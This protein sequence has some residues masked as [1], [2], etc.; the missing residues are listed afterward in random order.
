MRISDAMPETED[1]DMPPAIDAETNVQN[2]DLAIAHWLLGPERTSIDPEANAAYWQT[3]AASW[4]ITEAEARR[5]LC[6]NCEYFDNTPGSLEA[7]E[8]VPLDAYD[9][10]GGG[11]GYCT[12]LEFIC[13]SLRSC[14]A[15]E[16]KEFEED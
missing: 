9:M 4:N 11:R 1:D 13:H 3:L 16:E 15:W 14:Q 8:V 10:D 7:M 5:Q 6:A 12:K 2:R